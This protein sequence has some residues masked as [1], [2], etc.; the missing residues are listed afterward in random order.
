MASE[1]DTW[2]GQGPQGRH[3]A[4]RQGQGHRRSAR[5]N[6][7]GQGQDHRCNARDD[8]TGQ[9]QGRRRAGQGSCRI[10]ACGCEGV[11]SN[12]V[13]AGG[14]VTKGAGTDASSN[15]AWGYTGENFISPSASK[16]LSPA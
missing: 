14:D 1:D 16:N 8:D 10:A 12:A 15:T 4:T 6:D 7:T 2:K 5:N 9:G 13:A 11:T 3:Y